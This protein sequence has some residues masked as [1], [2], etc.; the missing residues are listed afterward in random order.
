VPLY[1]AALAAAFPLA[2]LAG[3]PIG[4]EAG[5]RAVGG[6]VVLAF[7]VGGLAAGLYRDRDRAGLATTLVIVAVIAGRDGRIVAMVAAGLVL[8]AAE[9][10]LARRRA[11]MLPW[12]AVTRVS[13]ALAVA[14][15]AVLI[16]QLGSAW[17]G[18][19]RAVDP[20]G[21]DASPDV[22]GSHPNIYL[23][24]ADGQGRAD[25]LA[26]RYGV[27]SSAF[28]ARLETAGFDVAG[29]SRSN[30]MLTQ[31][32]L[33]T[34]LNGAYLDE[35]GVPD[36]APIP[37][38]RLEQ[39][40]ETSGAF[41]LLW[42]AGYESIVIPSG[43]DSVRIQGADRTL[44][45][46][47]L[48][49]LEAVILGSTGLDPALRAVW[50]SYLADAL[51]G[52]TL[53]ALA[54]VEGLAG[55]AGQGSAGESRFVF[56]HLPVPHFPYIF[57]ADCRPVDRG[58]P[59]LAGSPETGSART[60]EE[61]DR[62][63]LVTADQNACVQSLLATTAER[64]AVNDPTAIVI[65]F[66]DHGPDARLDWWRPDDAG[67]RDRLSTLFAARTPGRP[68]LFPDDVSLINVFPILANAYLG[69]ALQT[70]EDRTFFGPDRETGAVR[71][72]SVEP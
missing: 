36:G 40:I 47:Q 51:R 56:A 49:E 28:L 67:M 27:D 41:R 60:P 44:D 72:V 7:V 12:P 20:V 34:M 24:L 22:S 55:E 6:A 39:A 29:H 31:L 61:V 71:Q 17:L 5:G 32:T 19:S 1:P 25:V 66:S 11:P 21:L 46:G 30:Y 18:R 48:S 23:V 63:I 59:N 62:E 50:P 64:I 37:A 54:T 69:T 8:L 42:L 9:A 14:L 68:D 52:R 70:Q 16:V 58:G 3:N 38:G 15:V 43:Y 45:S 4:P 2:F 35:L 10:W 13:T 53:D 33:S 65:L 26:E 57:D